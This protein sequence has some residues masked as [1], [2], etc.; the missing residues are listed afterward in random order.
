[1]NNQYFNDNK[2]KQ[3]G[4][5]LLPNLIFFVLFFIGC[6]VNN[7]IAIFWEKDKAAGILIGK[8][9]LNEIPADTVEKYLRIELDNANGIA[10]LGNYQLLD[11]DILFKPPIPLTGGLTYRVIFHEN[12]IG[13]ITVPGPDPKDGPFVTAVMPSADTLPENLLK[14]YIQFSRPVREG[15]ALK[16]IVLLNNANDTVR[17]VFLDLQPEL[18]DSSRTTLTLWLDPGR[19]KRALQPNEKLGN[20]LK[21]GEIYTLAIA[22]NWKDASGLPLVKNFK[23]RFTVAARDTAVP[24]PAAWNIQPPKAGSGDGL[25]VLLPEPLDHFLLAETVQ[26]LDDAGKQVPGHFH[27]LNNEKLLQYDADRSWRAGN[28]TL[29]I[30]SYLEDLAGNNLNRLFDRDIFMPQQKITAGNYFDLHFLIE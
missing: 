3:I 12:E 23:K 29:R 8:D 4:L 5:G 19:I 18:W 9:L 22:N 16:H 25:Q 24:N 21:Q 20:P 28:Y 27:I 13:R 7:G 1:M 17:N 14:F 11:G 30:Y 26:V 6:R 2:L 15:E 10:M